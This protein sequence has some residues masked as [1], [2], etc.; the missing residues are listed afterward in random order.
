MRLLLILLFISQTLS[1]AP[2]KTIIQGELKNGAQRWIRVYEYTNQLTYTP[3]KISIDSIGKNGTFRME[4]QIEKGETKTIFFA[5][6]RFRSADFYIEAGKTYSLVFDSLDFSIQDELYSPLTS[7]F[8]GLIFHL[9]NNPDD[10]NNRITGFLIELMNFTDNEFSDVVRNRDSE[11]FET[12]KKR[13]DSLFA[14]VKNPFFQSLL[15]YSLAELQFT[16]RLKNNAYFVAKYFNDRPFLYE[17]PAFMNFFNVYFDKYIYTVSRR[18]APADLEQHVVREPNYKAL[19]DSL[20]KD[21]LLKNEVVRDMVLIKN[22][23]QMYFAN[24]LHREKIFDMMTEIS[25]VSK[26][27]KHRQIASA[28][29]SEM[30][31]HV[32]KRKAPPLVAREA[33]GQYFHL[34]SVKGMY[35]YVLFYTTYC[36][37]CYPE[38][39]VLN[40]V[41]QKFSNQVYFVSVSMDVNFL[42]F[43]Y[44][45]NDYSYPWE[46]VNF[47][48]NFDIEDEWGVKVYPHAFMIDPDGY[49]INDNAPMPSEFLETYLREILKA[50]IKQ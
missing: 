45:M 42:K 25:R 32:R 2:M 30:N 13:I 48:R 34:D 21:S 22:L 19:L 47:N 9:P 29:L 38:L 43:Y 6:E 37:M 41:Y 1:A 7:N 46:F 28:L 18:I 23:H 33:D 12:Y 24:Y 4:L 40:T 20:G 10:L 31:L 16:A 36:R 49:I 44:F 50:E 27:V 39:N 15:E 5:V 17:N 3:R 35:T 11:K 14:G 8:P 26:F